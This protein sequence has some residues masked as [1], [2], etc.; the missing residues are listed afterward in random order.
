MDEIKE[1]AETIKSYKSHARIFFSHV[2]YSMLRATSANDGGLVVGSHQADLEKTVVVYYQTPKETWE[3]YERATRK[4]LT[5]AKFIVWQ[6][7]PNY[8]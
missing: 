2:G 8:G 5:G 7:N 4:I 1:L 3:A 6:G